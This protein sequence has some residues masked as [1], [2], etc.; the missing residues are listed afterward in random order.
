VS[1]SPV[2]VVTDSTAYLPDEL[3]AQHGITVV[4][5]QVVVDGRPFDETAD[6][7]G[8]DVAEALRHSRSVS[9]SR[10]APAQLVEVYERLAA[11]GA[12]A[13]VSIH[14]SRELSGT[15]ES[16]VLAAREVEVPVEVVDSRTLGMATGFAALRARE[17]LDGDGSAEEAA[18]AARR[19]AEATWAGFYVNTLE[20]LRRGG[21]V[22]VARAL[23]G[24]ALAVKPLLHVVDGGIAPLEN[25]RTASRALARL[26]ALAVEQAGDAPV[27]VAVHHLVNPERASSLAASLASRLPGLREL[28]V[29]EVGPVVGAHV[30]P[31]LV[32]V[33][34]APV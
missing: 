20:H 12:P 29:K 10:P 16:A 31:G 11:A 3:V 34:V 1:R 22:T 30:G 28:V 5:L 18:D 8:P 9:T 21:R 13:I 15:Y 23:I 32:A 19:R 25:V 6:V 24:T 33:V 17:V 7:T 26:E 27:D 14:L 4:P 2:A